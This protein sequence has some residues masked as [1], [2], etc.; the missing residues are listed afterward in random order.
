M[1]QRRNNKHVRK[2]KD[3]L[4]IPPHLLNILGVPQEP[5]GSRL[6]A[7]VP[8]PMASV[9]VCLQFPH[10]GSC[11]VSAADLPG[12]AWAPSPWNDLPFTQQPGRA[13]GRAALC[14]LSPEGPLGLLLP[15]PWWLLRLLPS[16]LL[17]DQNSPVL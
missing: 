3:P 12:E 4:F 16:V 14:L 17:L 2:I 1:T 5:M 6:G 15:L 13:L 8:E 10:H 7:S 9:G 11:R